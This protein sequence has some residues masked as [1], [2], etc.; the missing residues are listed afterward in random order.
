LAQSIEAAQNGVLDAILELH[1]TKLFPNVIDDLFENVLAEY[2]IASA[3]LDRGVGQGQ[4]VVEGQTATPPSLMSLGQRLDDRHRSPPLELALHAWARRFHLTDKLSET[5]E[6]LPWIL[7]FGRELCGDKLYRVPE[8]HEK[9]AHS[10]PVDL[11]PRRE[12]IQVPD[13]KPGVNFSDYVKSVKRM[14]KAHYA[15]VRKRGRSKPPQDKRNRDHYKWFVLNVC[16]GFKFPQIADMLDAQV[17]DDAI[18]KGIA[19]VCDE[20][21][22]SGNR[23]S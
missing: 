14:L 7:K 23:S 22:L 3:S 2:L 6:C 11:Q 17:Q 5:G 8:S 10:F 1:S 15:A 20:L 9:S 13:P 18:R 16:G 19:T 21:G 12:G 4:G